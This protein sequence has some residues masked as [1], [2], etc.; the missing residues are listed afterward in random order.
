MAKHPGGRPL[1]FETPEE[2]QGL[3]DA[4]FKECEENDTPLTITGLAMYLDT[5]RQGLLNYA[6]RDEF[7]DTIKRAKL[8]VE[9]YAELQVYKGK[10]AAGP[11]FILKNHGW[12]DKSELEMNA[13]IDTHEMTEEELDAEIA[14][15]LKEIEE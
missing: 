2:V 14:Q 11:I 10:N 4:Y 3:C 8:K 12:T 9:N 7:Y 6:E 5:T 1:K 13:R 15:K